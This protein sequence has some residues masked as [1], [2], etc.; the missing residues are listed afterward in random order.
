MALT[1]TA[2]A[3]ALTSSVS[4]AGFDA[5]RKGLSVRME[6][7][8]LVVWLMLGQI[9]IF[10]AWWLLG[11]A[12][13]VRSGYWLPGTVDVAGN[14]I[15]N[16]LFIRAV[17]TGELSTT[18]PLLA[19]TPVLTLGVAAF[20]LGELP[21]TWQLFGVIA[22]VAG[23]FALNLPGNFDLRGWLQR[24]RANRG[25]HSM[26]LVAL[27]WSGTASIDKLALAHAPVPFHAFFQCAGIAVTLSVFLVLRGR[28][29]SLAT[30]AQ[31][32]PRYGLAVLLSAMAMGMQLLAIQMMYVAFMEAMKRAVGMVG[33]MVNGRVFFGEPITGQKV[34]AVGAMT[35]GVLLIVLSDA[36]GF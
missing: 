6:T 5:A 22:V 11:E 27:I 25:G 32:L 3:A 7:V 23:A 36:S 8:P 28:A 35:V 19:F 13:P 21:S 17:R 33:A 24:F 12:A 15:A 14:V 9:P 30:V 34:V 29:S 20:L 4:W 1:P 31:H 2:I 16:L 18:I 26:A 10:L